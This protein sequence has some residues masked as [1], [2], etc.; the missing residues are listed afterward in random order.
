M[1]LMI[2]HKFLRAL[3]RND[4]NAAIR[5]YDAALKEMQLTCIEIAKANTRYPYDRRRI[6]A[7]IEAIE[8]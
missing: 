6:I 1:L 3:D 5:M 4:K 2:R 8:C 7:K